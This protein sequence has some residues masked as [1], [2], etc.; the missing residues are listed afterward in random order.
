MR[1]KKPRTGAPKPKLLRRA[2]A[3]KRNILPRR[4]LVRVLERSRVAPFLGR[5][6]AA[7][8]PIERGQFLCIYAGRVL[9][10]DTVD[11]IVR[12]HS[13]PFCP[14]VSYFL[15]IDNNE[16]WVVDGNPSQTNTRDAAGS[17]INDPRG[18]KGAR[19]NCRFYHEWDK[20]EG[21]VLM[22]VQA[23][24]NI[25]RDEELWTSYGSHY[26]VFTGRDPDT[27]CSCQ[28]RALTGSG[29]TSMESD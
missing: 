6:V 21:T 26:W 16:D 8:E 12:E 17:F 23:T 22:L 27:P 3:V 2:E 14:T 18:I 7:N 15:L 29:E 9:H 28:Q 24:R 19:A 20:E 13:N 5:A 10:N 25:K 4:R 11:H 1:N